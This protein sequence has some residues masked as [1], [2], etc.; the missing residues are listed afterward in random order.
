MTQP[1]RPTSPHLTIYRKQ[2]TAVLSIMHRMTGIALYAGSVLILGFLYIMSYAPM[3]FEQMHVCLSS[4]LGRLI[5]FGW[6]LAFFFHFYNGIRHLF[7]DIGK[8][9]EVATVT[10]TGWAALVAT[11]LSTFGVWAY[12][13]YMVGAL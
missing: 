4:F 5:L 9:F 1:D 2:I 8:G 12:G 6:T 7:W 11:L 3:H 13:Y 10:R